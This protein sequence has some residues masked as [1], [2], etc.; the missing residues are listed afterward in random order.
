MGP[1]HQHPVRRGS[2]DATGPRTA[3]GPSTNA[4][5]QCHRSNRQ[6]STI[7]DKNGAH[8]VLYVAKILHCAQLS[9]KSNTKRGHVSNHVFVSAEPAHAA[10]GRLTRKWYN[11]KVVI[12][13]M[14]MACAFEVE[15]SGRGTSESLTHGGFIL[16]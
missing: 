10:R 5:T 12:Y 9:H 8:L 4:S 2:A 3:D 6:N 16:H 7:L 13:L 15:V 1:P 14:D 11:N